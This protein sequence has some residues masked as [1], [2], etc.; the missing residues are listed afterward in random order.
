MHGVAA[1]ACRER[2]THFADI[3]TEQSRRLGQW[4]DWPN[5]YYTMSDDNIAYIWHFLKECHARGWI[6]LGHRVMP[7]C[8]RCG[9]SLLPRKGLTRSVAVEA[10][11]TWSRC[12]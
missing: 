10:G 2:V 11:E 5:S 9:T 6:D 3:Q 8:T 4:M 12:A 1:R 7:W